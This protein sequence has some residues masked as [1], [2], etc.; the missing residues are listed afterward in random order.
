IVKTESKFDNVHRI[1]TD[2]G[3]VLDLYQ[4]G[5]ISEE[6]SIEYEIINDLKNAPE[7]C[8]VMN[9]TVYH[10]SVSDNLLVSFGGLIGCFPNE[11]LMPDGE[12]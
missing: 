10:N 4:S 3:S 12:R 7:T 6:T 9:G 2:Q 5:G 11:N 1:Y 8:T